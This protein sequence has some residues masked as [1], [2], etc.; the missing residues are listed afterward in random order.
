MSTSKMTALVVDEIKGIGFQLASR[1]KI[2]G[3]DV[4]GTFRPQTSGD[5]SGAE[6]SLSSHR[7]F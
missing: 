5:P 7:S 1:P 4:F 6:V 3:Y 2:V